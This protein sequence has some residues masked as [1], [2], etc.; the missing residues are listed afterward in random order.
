[1]HNYA[2]IMRMARAFLSYRSRRTVPATLP[3]RL[4]VET[5]SACNL[6]CTMC[7]NKFMTASGKGLM[8]MDLF[9]KIVDEARGFASDLN[10]HHRG[11]PLLNP[12]LFDMIA[13]ARE[14][15]L[16]TRFHSNGALLSAERADKLLRAQPDLVS[17]S[18]DGFGK[19]SYER[20]RVGATFEATIDNI[21]G[22][23]KLRRERG[24]RLP[25]VVVEK[26]LFRN[27]PAPA[28]ASEVRDTTRR[29]REAGVD[30]I[31]EKEEYIWA[32][33]SA[34]ELDAPPGNMV[35]TFPWYAMVICW[36]GTVTPCPQDFHAKIELG[37]VARQSIAEVWNGHAYQDLR[38]RLTS[39]LNS[40]A[41]CRKCDRL[42]R[43]TVAGIPLQYMFTF[44]TDQLVGYRRGWRRLIGTAERN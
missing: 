31:I 44:L 27:D 30:E 12:A 25:Y 7:P 34:P 32:E 39:D 21:T 33:E 40:L 15:G 22:F 36:D 16:K 4:W 10:L 41:L 35:C 20:V 1:M 18:V 9:K 28:S 19:E 13:Y 8:G 26:I 2:K 38:H 3:L 42:R 29:L 5:S 23:L 11:E 6:R 37:S 14:A 17:F 43:K 24:L